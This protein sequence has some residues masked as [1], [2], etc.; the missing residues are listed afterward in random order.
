[1]KLDNIKLIDKVLGDKYNWFEPK[2]I[3]EPFEGAVALATLPV[4]VI[5]RHVNNIVIDVLDDGL[6]E[7]LY[8]G[9]VMDVLPNRFLAK[10]Y[11]HDRIIG[12]LNLSK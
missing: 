2:E 12:H 9:W 10:D 11:K 3:T 7:V 4:N 5:Y 1:M 6:T 8:T